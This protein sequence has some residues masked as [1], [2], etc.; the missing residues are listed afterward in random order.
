[1]KV[2]IWIG[3]IFVASILNAILGEITG[4]KIGYLLFYL[5]VSFLARKLCQKWDEHKEAKAQKKRIAEAVEALRGKDRGFSSSATSGWQC[6]CGRFHPLYETSCVCGKSKFDAAEQPKP[7]AVTAQPPAAFEQKNQQIRFCRRCGEKLIDDSRFCRMC[8]EEVITGENK[9]DFVRNDDLN[10]AEFGEMASFCRKCGNKLSPQGSSQCAFCGTVVEYV[11]Q[12]DAPICEPDSQ[13]KA[14]PKEK[15]SKKS[16][17]I[18]VLFISLAVSLLAMVILA[19]AFFM[20]PKISPQ[21]IN[22]I[23]GCPEFYNI[24][25]GMTLDKASRQIALKHNTFKGMESSSWFEVDEEMKDSHI[26]FEEDQVFNLYGIKTT[27]VHVS[28]DGNYVDGVMFIFEKEK[29][30]LERMKKLYSQIYGTATTQLPELA[31]WKGPK[32]TIDVYDRELLFDGED[33]TIIVRYSRTENG[34]YTTL[35]FDG[36]E[37]D[38][39]NFLG[40]NYAFDKTPSYYVNGLKMDEDYSYQK[41]SPEGF[42]GFEKYTLYPQFEYMGIDKGYTAIEF[43]IADDKNAIE[44]VTYLFLLDENNVLDRISYIQKALTKQ[45]GA[46]DSCTYTSTQYSGP[47]IVDISFNELRQLVGDHTQGMYHIQWESD[48]RRITLGLTIS[49]DKAYYDGS[50]A[51]AD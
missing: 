15:R 32:T 17:G 51:F 26:I 7:I 10:P 1:M 4:F 12:T 37:I 5:G 20:K 43:D 40:D 18:I 23:N 41:F 29:V 45:Y 6:V 27:G 16:K 25:F 2:L 49:E 36:P 31:T 30:S 47:G 22:S 9:S 21:D 8:G 35:S 42:P 46:Y 19:A 11:A 3:C 48:G 28:F 50:V 24:E 34:Q 14:L 33:Q 38:P 39:C 44:V 13:D